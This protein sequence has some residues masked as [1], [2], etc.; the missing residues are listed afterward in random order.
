MTREEFAPLV[1]G[2]KAVYTYEGFIKDKDAFDV[3]FELLKDLDYKQCSTAIH[4]FMSSETR[5]PTPADIRRIAA[6]IVRPYLPTEIEAFDMVKNAVRRLNGYNTQEVFNKLPEVVRRAVGNSHTLVEWTGWQEYGGI[7]SN[8]FET[9]IASHFMKTYR[10]V[11]GSYKQEQQ[12]SPEVRQKINGLMWDALEGKNE[13]INQ[14]HKRVG[15]KIHGA[16][17]Q[18]QE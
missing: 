16:I 17:E 9:V 4:K 8:E 18:S 11:C 13:R 2:M 3:W 7:K 15:R 12:L 10:A 5:I 14:Y 1:K 6:E